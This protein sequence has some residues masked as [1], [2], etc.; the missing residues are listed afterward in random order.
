ME[1]LSGHRQGKGPMH[2]SLLCMAFAFPYGD[3]GGQL[4]LFVHPTMQALAMHHANCRLRH[5]QPTAMFGRG[6]PCHLVQEASSFLGRK[7][8][9]Q[10]RAIVRVAMVLDQ[11]AFLRLRRRF[12]HQCAHTTDVILAGAPC[13]DWHVPPA[14]PGPLGRPHLTAQVLAGFGTTDPGI[15]RL[16]GPLIRL[17]A[18][19][20]TLTKSAAA[21]G[22]IHHVS[23]IHGC[24]ACFFT[25]AAPSRY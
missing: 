23:T 6:M 22:G 5:V 17:H 14:A 2:A 13:R 4:V 10:A 18:I 8:F 12:F 1:F 15:P 19:F 16:R 20:H 9:R 11:T 25:R 7:R 3:L 21:W 24:M